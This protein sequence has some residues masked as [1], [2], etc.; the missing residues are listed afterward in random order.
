MFKYSDGNTPVSVSQLFSKEYV[1]C[2]NRNCSCIYA[3][4]ATTEASNRTFGY[5]GIYIWDHILQTI[6]INTSYPCFKRG[7]NNLENL[8]HNY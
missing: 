2:N 6:N 5:R 8:S 4:I 3:S 1:N 7:N